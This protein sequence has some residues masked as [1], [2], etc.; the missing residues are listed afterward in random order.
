MPTRPTPKIPRRTAERQEVLFQKLQAFA[1]QVQGVAGRRPGM[2]VPE[3]VRR[4]AEALLFDVE[5]FREAP[6]RRV[7]PDTAPSYGGLAA[8]LGEALTAL[9]AFE[10]RHTHWDAVRLQPMW[11]VSHG[12]M[13]VRR[14]APRPGSKA[15]ARADALDE[16]DRERREAEILDLRRKLVRRLEM[17]DR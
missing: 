17:A 4:T 11:L 2:G 5:P 6:R 9:V 8:Q 10:T 16:R 13:K 15:A 12:L 7:L 3:K 1:R 14:L